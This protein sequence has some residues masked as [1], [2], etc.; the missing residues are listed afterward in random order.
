M[1]RIYARE[2]LQTVVN[3]AM[4][5]LRGADNAS[6]QAVPELA[7][8]LGADELWTGLGSLI[9]DMDIVAQATMQLAPESA[10]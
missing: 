4:S 9:Q 2:A 5:W 1:S 10:G 8:E 7:R 3:E 6:T